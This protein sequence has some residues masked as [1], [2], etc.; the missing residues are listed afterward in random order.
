MLNRP[1]ID[2]RAVDWTDGLNPLRVPGWSRNND[3]YAYAAL[4]DPFF[5]A[6]RGAA[7]IENRIYVSPDPSAQTIT[8]GATVDYEVPCEPNF[9]LFAYAAS[10]QGDPGATQDFLF[11]I[12]DSETGASLF[13]QPA[14]MSVMNPKRNGTLNR[15]PYNLLSTPHLYKSPSYPVVRIINTDANPQLC[16]VT[17]FGCVEYDLAT[18]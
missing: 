2:P 15:S 5:Q 16:R 7:G 18:I 10:N 6:L 8:P 9:W 3:P 13:S 4:Q 12:A 1:W 14:S 11:N 17:L